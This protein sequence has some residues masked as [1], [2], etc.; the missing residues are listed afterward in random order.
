MG[1]KTLHLTNAYHPSSGGIRAFYRA[2]LAAANA[3]RRPMR[4]IVPGVET[5]VEEVGEFGRIYH[6]AAP[7]SPI[8][9]SSYRLLLPHAFL[10]RRGAVRQILEDEQPDLIEVCDKYSLCHLAGLLRRQWLRGLPRPTL[11]G[12]SCE[13]FEDNITAVGGGRVGARLARWYVGHVY[14]GQ[15]DYHLANSEYTARELRDNMAPAWWREVHVVPMGVN[16]DE[17][18][19]HHRSLA[20][21]AEMAGLVYGRNGRDSADPATITW[22]LYAGRLAREKNLALL[23]DT[24]ETLNRTEDDRGGVRRTFRLLIVGNGPEEAS[25]R[26]DVQRR[27]PG[28]VLFWGHVTDRATL[29][30]LYASCDAFVHPNPREPFGIGPLEA[31]ASG[32][33]VVAPSSGGLLAYA[34][35]RNA[36]LVDPNATRVADAVIEAITPQAS[37]DARI[38]SARETAAAYGWSSVTRVIFSVYDALHAR[39]VPVSGAQPSGV[40][41]AVVKP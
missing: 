37:R 16:V 32:V 39:R 28:H 35:E 2:M 8:V 36:W 21:R 5:R 9:D 24:L 15:F 30:Q 14:A 17:L 13:R 4:L 33:P 40:R 26:R 31:M 1:I 23:L 10:S 12:L 22:L 19:P 25:L 20:L 7:R 6:I 18:G 38:A 29:A 41:E 27:M 11:V 34:N 3:A